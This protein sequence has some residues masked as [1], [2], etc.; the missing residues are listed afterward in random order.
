MKPLLSPIK[1]AYKLSE[2]PKG[3]RFAID[4]SVKIQD[5]RKY[6]YRRRDLCKGDRYCEF[7]W[8]LWIFEKRQNQ[9]YIQESLEAFWYL[10]EKNR[11]EK[12]EKHYS[13][14]LAL[15]WNAIDK[16]PECTIAKEFFG[17]KQNEFSDEIDYIILLKDYDIYP[18]SQ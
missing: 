3:I 5:Y 6:F 16:I 12:H 9:R 4:K 14:T 17:N 2:K 7:L 15:L 18:S 11:G 8:P 1:S 10:Y 13:S